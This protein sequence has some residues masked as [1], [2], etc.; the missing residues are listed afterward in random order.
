MKI[1]SFN[2]LIVSKD[3]ESAVQLFEALGF[4]QRHRKEG[5]SDQNITGIRMKD[6]NGFHLDVANSDF[7]QDRTLIRMNV[8]NLDEAVALLEA[9]GFKRAP[10]FSETNETPSSRFA[11]MVSPSG[12]VMNVIQHLKDHD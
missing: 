1:T 10:S 11:I 3:P 9:R 4:Q 5:I 8:D 2:P 12:F 7:A 6:A